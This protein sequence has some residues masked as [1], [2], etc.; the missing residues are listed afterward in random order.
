MGSMLSMYVKNQT[1]KVKSLSL[2]L[3][4]YKYVKNFENVPKCLSIKTYSFLT[5][6]AYFSIP[7]IFSNLNSYC[8]NLLDLKTSRN[9]LKKHSGTKNCSGLSLF[10]QIVLVISKKKS[11]ILEQFFLTGG[12]KIFVTKYHYCVEIC[13]K[14]QKKI[15]T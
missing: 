3:E 15:F 8:P 4:S 2:K 10:E 7:I 13:K 14:K 11:W 5:F 9:K 6:P 1:K 12:Q